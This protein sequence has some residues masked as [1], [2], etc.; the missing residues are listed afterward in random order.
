MHR[1]KGGDC[2]NGFS[3]LQER[4]WGMRHTTIAHP[5]IIC[6][7]LPVGYSNVVSAAKFLHDRAQ[8][9][10]VRCVFLVKKSN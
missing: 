4:S 5:F 7:S 6:V 2:Y 8:K 1:M 10:G 9:E 3:F